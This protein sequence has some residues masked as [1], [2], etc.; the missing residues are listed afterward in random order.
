METQEKTLVEYLKEIGLEI[1]VVWDFNPDALDWAKD[2]NHFYVTLS[3]DGEEMSF[4]FYQGTGIGDEPSLERVV[5]NLALDRTYAQMTVEEFGDELGWDR[6]TLKTHNLI[7]A[8][9][10]DYERVIGDQSLMDE[11]YKKV[12]A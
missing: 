6:N 4:W 9:N 11:I 2:A 8:L 1:E 12:S 3:K 10:K 7:V 5:E